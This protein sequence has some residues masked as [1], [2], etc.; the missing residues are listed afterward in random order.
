MSA[1]SAADSC[2][3]ICRTRNKERTVATNRDGSASASSAFR[4][5][6]TTCCVRN[7]SS[8]V[9]S[10][11]R[12][13]SATAST[14]LRILQP[15]P[16][17]RVVPSAAAW[18]RGGGR[19]GAGDAPQAP[20]LSPGFGQQ[21]T[22]RDDIV[23]AAAFLKLIHRRG[24]S[25]QLQCEVEQHVD[26]LNRLAAQHAVWRWRAR[27]KSFSDAV[28]AVRGGRAAPVGQ[29]DAPSSGDAGARR[30]STRTTRA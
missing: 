28:S 19:G 18:K 24:T 12:R 14:T 21:T 29:C 4:R 20:R 25:E 22:E 23:D 17:Q 10:L 15:S 30:A 16:G 5:T 13:A 11:L 27:P 9:W 8:N 2:D 1:S 3:E 6:A 7:A 26:G